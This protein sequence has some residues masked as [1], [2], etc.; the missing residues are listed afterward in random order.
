MRRVRE[1]PVGMCRKV[2]R[3]LRRNA[4]WRYVG[5]HP[6]VGSALCCGPSNGLSEGKRRLLRPCR[7]QGER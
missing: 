3:N 5:A 6:C 1:L 7:P 4:G 2:Q